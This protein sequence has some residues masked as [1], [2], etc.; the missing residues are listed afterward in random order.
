MKKTLLFLILI[1][2]LL[3][4]CAGPVKTCTETSTNVPAM[5]EYHAQ[6][7]AMADKIFNGQIGAQEAL[8]A[9]YTLEEPLIQLVD[10]S[11][12][13]HLLSAISQ[14]LDCYKNFTQELVNG[15]RSDN[16]AI[17][18]ACTVY[19]DEYQQAYDDY[20]ANCP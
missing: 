11:N 16:P 1:A 19:I 10:P 14:E 13:S 15:Q 5:L 4:G 17:Y 7:Q 8:A 3:A 9:F 6:V 2:L 18:S 20:L 12:Y